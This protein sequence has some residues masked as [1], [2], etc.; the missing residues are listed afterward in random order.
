MTISSSA[1][2]TSVNAFLHNLRLFVGM[3]RPALPDQV[4]DL[5]IEAAEPTVYA[6][7]MF[8]P[9]LRVLVLPVKRVCFEVT[10]E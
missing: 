8:I 1:A 10:I 2:K 7:Y 3:I 6:S 9:V 5:P 4:D